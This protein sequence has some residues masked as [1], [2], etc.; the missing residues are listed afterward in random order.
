MD[1]NETDATVRRRPSVTGIQQDD[2]L[3][4]AHV[5]RQFHPSIGGLEQAVLGLSHAL[6][7]EF[8]LQ[9]RIITLDRIFQERSR[10]LPRS[11]R[12]ESLEVLRIPFFGS[13][14]YPIAPSVL[15]HIGWADIVHVHAIDFFF[16]YL[17]AT[18][19]VHR[20][21]LIATTHGG[22][23]HT[24]FAAAFKQVFFRSV[25]RLSSRAYAR[26][27][28]TSDADALTFRAIAPDRVVTVE[29]G[30]EVDKFLDAGARSAQPTL[31]SF[32]R[33]SSNKR[34]PA[35]FPILRFLRAANPAWRL[36]I[37][38]VEADVTAA[39]LK[40]AAVNEGVGDALDL[41]VAPTT[42]QLTELAGRS[43]YFISA[44][45][46]EGFG[47]AP[48]EAM[49]AGLMPVL[50]NIA[51]FERI[52]AG[53]GAGILFDADDPQGAAAS[54]LAFHAQRPPRPGEERAR[55]INAARQYDWRHAAKRYVEHYRFAL[56][57]TDHR[58]PMAGHA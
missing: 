31:V 44:S 35:L 57:T 5:V 33:L 12:I 10:A 16:D 40:M 43:S 19:F 13:M 30:V 21:P 42:E 38:G 11:E 41:V 1:K 7:Q 15:A 4:V 45:A 3:K 49:A 55:L 8:G 36:I 23:F 20:K 25:T 14:R 50:S 28:A 47:I 37:A 29:N 18:K 56:G 53:A 48:I 58:V 52:I 17:A 24:P 51:P 27:C 26:I 46:Y 22:F 32:G 39:Q 9:V 34:I 54:I 6:Q 2:R